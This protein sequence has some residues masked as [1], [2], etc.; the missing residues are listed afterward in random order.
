LGQSIDGIQPASGKMLGAQW[1]QLI[2]FRN[3][4]A[5]H[6]RLVA[7]SGQHQTRISSFSST[8]SSAV[9]KFV[10]QGAIEGIQAFGRL[11]VI[12][13]IRSLMSKMIFS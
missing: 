6:K 1:P 3:V 8:R 10:Q 13:A 2:D 5:R 11:K 12:V 7:A 4:G 9:R